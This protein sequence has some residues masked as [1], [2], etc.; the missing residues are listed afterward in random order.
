TVT[1]EDVTLEQLGGA[2][3]HATQSGVATFVSADEKACLDEVRYLLSLLPSNNLEEP[4]TVVTGDDPERLCPE[5]RDLMPTSPKQPYD[6]HNVIAAVVDDAD[7]FEYAPLWAQNIVC[8]FARLDGH[9]VGIVGNQPQVL[10]A[11]RDI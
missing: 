3:C 2:I 5:L 10:R 9:A 4:P 6:M 8:G 1:G 11:L 7:F